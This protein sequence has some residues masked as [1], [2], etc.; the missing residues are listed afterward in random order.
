MIGHAPCENH[1]PME[2]ITLA[3]AL[4]LRLSYSVVPQNTNVYTSKNEYIHFFHSPC[5]KIQSLLYHI[6]V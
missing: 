4:L 5:L 2:Q 1:K 6:K 3:Q